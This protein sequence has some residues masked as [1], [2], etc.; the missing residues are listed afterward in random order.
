MINDFKKRRKQDLENN[1]KRVEFMRD[2]G[3]DTVVEI[4]AGK[5]LSGLTRRIDRDLRA[6]SVSTPG[7][8]DELVKSL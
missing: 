3:T 2:A 1:Q 4:G 5:V 7:D 6:I 8:I